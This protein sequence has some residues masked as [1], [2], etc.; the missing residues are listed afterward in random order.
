[1][2]WFRGN[3]GRMVRRARARLHRV[4]VG[5]VHRPRRRCVA[6]L[7]RYGQKEDRQIGDAVR[8]DSSMAARKTG[9]RRATGRACRSGGHRR[10]ECSTSA[11]AR[12]GPERAEAVP[13][14]A[15]HLQ[16]AQLL[17]SM[18]RDLASLG[19][20]VEQLKASIEQLKASQQQSPARPRPPRSRLLSRTCGQDVGASAAAVRYA[21]AQAD[22]FISATAS[23]SRPRC[24]K[25]RLITRRA[26]RPQQQDHG[27]ASGRAGIVIGAA[28]ADA[29]ALAPFFRLATIAPRRTA[30]AELREPIRRSRL[31]IFS[32]PGDCHENRKDHFSWYCGP[33]HHQLGGFCSTTAYGNGYPS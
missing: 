27:R 32:I 4:A 17:Q 20:E 30:R 28:A 22:D 6:V 8:A 3:A 11:T 24:H 2:A 23:R 7:R 29:R 12:S 18:A 33:H 14:T 10:G 13:P 21:G 5:R 15:A 19:Q 1:M 9:A 25:R 16:S 26:I 31:S